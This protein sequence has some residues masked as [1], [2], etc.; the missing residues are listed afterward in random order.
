M[1]LRRYL[2]LIL[3]LAALGG[4]F[5]QFALNAS[6]PGLEDWGPRAWDLLRYF[7]IWTNLLVAGLM[8]AEASGRRVRIGWLGTAT[9]NIAMVGLV[10]QVLL[11][12][13]VPLQGAAWVTDFLMHAFVPMAMVLWW[14]AFAPRPVRLARLPVWLIWPVIYCVVALVRGAFEGRYPYFFLDITKFGAAQIAINIA[15][16]VMVFAVFG[17]L[18]WGLARALPGAK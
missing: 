7:T 12:P 8:L 11:A 16:L 9:L 10:Y 17:V 5:G 13:E 3:A 2:S 18:L 4:V 15:G 1:T 6:K 14:V